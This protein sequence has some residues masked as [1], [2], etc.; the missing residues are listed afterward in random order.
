MT[1][2]TDWRRY[3]GDG[4]TPD[5]VPPSLRGERGRYLA[6]SRLVTAVNTIA[7]GRSQEIPMPGA[8]TARDR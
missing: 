4:S 5:G 3:R 2:V 7:V 6:D 1:V 8:A